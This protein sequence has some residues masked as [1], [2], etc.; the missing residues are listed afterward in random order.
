LRDR[1]SLTSLRIIVHAVMTTILIG[2]IFLF[3]V[4][5]LFKRMLWVSRRD[6]VLVAI[7]LFQ[8]VIVIYFYV[9]NLF[10]RLFL[11]RILPYIRRHN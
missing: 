3:G 8:V 5:R 7:L 2:M 11:R 10:E 4:D 6:L 9:F 1:V